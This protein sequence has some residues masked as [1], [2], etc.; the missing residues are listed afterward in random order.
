VRNR[1]LTKTVGRKGHKRINGK[2]REKR[3]EDGKGKGYKIRK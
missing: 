1:R 3:N 2:I